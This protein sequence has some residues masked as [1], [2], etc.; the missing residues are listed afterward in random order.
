V[1][2]GSGRTRRR[3]VQ[4]HDRRDGILILFANPIDVA[5]ADKAAAARP[6]TVIR[7]TPAM[8]AGRMFVLAEEQA[9]KASTAHPWPDSPGT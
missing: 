9:P 1:Q 2:R 6:G 7:L 3:A 8:P 4:S 5:S